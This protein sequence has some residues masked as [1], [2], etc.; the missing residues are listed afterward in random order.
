MI[1]GHLIS[2]R[3]AP[4]HFTLRFK[5]ILHE[6]GVLTL[7][8][9][10]QQRSRTADQFLDPA[11]ILDSLSWQLGPRSRARGLFLPAADGLVNRFDPR[12]RVL[13]RGKVIDFFAVEPIA[14]AYLDLV[15]TIEN[16]ELGQRQA[17]YAAGANRLQH[18]HGIK[19]AATPRPPGNDTVFLAA[20]AE[21]LAD[22]V[23]LLGREGA[24]A[25][26]RRIGF[27]DAQ[28]VADRI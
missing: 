10:R 11:D 27:A 6:N 2:L 22:L 15:E 14:D 18:Q 28:H 24:R 13:A 20:L 3:L 16:V 12:L 4:K 23:E 26:A 7:R 5:R 25:D 21:R 17:V 19:P 9:G 1:V 8:T